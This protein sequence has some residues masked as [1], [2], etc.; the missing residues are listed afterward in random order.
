MHSDP[1]RLEVRLQQAAEQ[2]GDTPGLPPDAVQA[3]RRVYRAVREAPMPAAPE[4]FA[5]RLEALTR[6]Y[7]EQAGLE[8][9]FVRA[10]ALLAPVVLGVA[11][12]PMAALLP[13]ALVERLGPLPWTLVA[14][15]ATAGAV[16]WA[17]DR[18]CLPL[19]AKQAPR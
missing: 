3:Y 14:A 8:T 1:N 4:G 16:A 7:D 11:A 5:A 2:E 13:S 6:D 15:I 18:L 19:T 17:I 10:A 9:G 12:A